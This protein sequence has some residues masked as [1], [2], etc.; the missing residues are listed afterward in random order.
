MLHDHQQQISEDRDDALTSL[1]RFGAADRRARYSHRSGGSTR[2]PIRMRPNNRRLNASEE[3]LPFSRV[4]VIPKSRRYV[5]HL[6][7]AKMIITGGRIDIAVAT[8]ATRM[9]SRSV[10]AAMK[11][12]TTKKM[13]A[14]TTKSA[15]VRAGVA[16][17]VRRRY[18]QLPRNAPKKS[19]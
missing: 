13:A 16:R 15:A 14:D 17:P 4:I 2:I 10:P 12:G 9:A 19:A 8:A 11:P 5:L 6:R 3:L 7:R 18:D 1:R